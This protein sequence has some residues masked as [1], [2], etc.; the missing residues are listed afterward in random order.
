MADLVHSASGYARGCRCERCR[1]D[2]AAKQAERRRRKRVAEAPAMTPAPDDEDLEPGR[3]E[4]KVSA[5]IEAL[6]GDNIWTLEMSRLEEQALIAARIVDRAMSGG[7]LHLTT[8]QHRIIRESVAEL[9]RLLSPVAAAG[10]TDDADDDICAQVCRELG[11]ETQA[12]TIARVT[13]GGEERRPK[14][15]AVPDARPEMRRDNS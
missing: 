4:S 1:A 2:H 5:E 14:L 6:A 11:V 7:K 3:L 15:R 9:R 10:V 12:E 13:G 8:P